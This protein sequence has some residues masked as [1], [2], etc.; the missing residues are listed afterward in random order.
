MKAAS[1]KEM[2]GM[3][4]V[5]QTLIETFSSLKTVRIFNR[6]LTER[7]RFKRNSGALYRMSQR[8][9]LY[10]SILRPVGEMLR[11][12]DGASVG[13]L[14]RVYGDGARRLS[15]REGVRHRITECPRGVASRF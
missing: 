9:S 6:E 14:R 1:Q 11:R 12:R 4:D 2:A 3:S 15:I 7:V 10:D 13:G 8:I 5:Y